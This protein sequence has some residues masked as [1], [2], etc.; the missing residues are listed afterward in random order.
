MNRT[1][2][3]LDTAADKKA[4]P[5]RPYTKPQILYRERLEA[6]ANVCSKSDP[7]TCAS[8]SGISS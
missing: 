7:A 3:R 8:L 6:I 4:G 2:K 1:D 5:R